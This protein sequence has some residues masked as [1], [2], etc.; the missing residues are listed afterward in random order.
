MEQVM[1]IENSSYTQLQGIINK[2]LRRLDGK[3]ID[4]KLIKADG[5]YTALIL[6]KKTV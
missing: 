1:I 2:E 6:Y 4:V 3:L 5:Y